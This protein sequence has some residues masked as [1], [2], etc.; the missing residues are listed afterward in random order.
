MYT[1][2]LGRLPLDAPFKFTG[3]N[4]GPAVGP[5]DFLASLPANDGPMSIDGI[6]DISNSLTSDFATHDFLPMTDPGNVNPIQPIQEHGSAQTMTEGW[7][8]EHLRQLSPS[9]LDL[10]HQT[11]DESKI[12]MWSYAPTTFGYVPFALV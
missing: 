2:E 12:P 6:F 3:N 7:D 4:Q 11:M 9:D 1:N 8:L 5:S 10:S